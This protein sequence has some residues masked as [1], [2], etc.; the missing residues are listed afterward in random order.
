MTPGAL[1]ERKWT[2]YIRITFNTEQGIADLPVD[3]QKAD[4]TC[5]VFISSVRAATGHQSNDYELWEWWLGLSWWLAYVGESPQRT[6]NFRD[7][8]ESPKVN[9]RKFKSKS[10]REGQGIKTRIL[11]D[12]TELHA[13]SDHPC[14]L[15]CCCRVAKVLGLFPLHLEPRAFA[16]VNS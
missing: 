14:F 13:I 8:K 9:N 3:A 11:G 16:R 7:V 10:G 12:C 1:W 2:S 15:R 5:F 6:T 4:Y